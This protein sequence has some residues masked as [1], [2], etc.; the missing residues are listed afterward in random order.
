MIDWILKPA[1][2]FALAAL[3]HFW[4]NRAAVRHFA[5]SLGFVAIL[6]MPLLP[7][8]GLSWKTKTAVRVPEVLAAID[9]GIEFEGAAAVAAAPAGSDAAPYPA[10]KIAVVAAWLAGVLACLMRL[11]PA[12]WK[13][14][15]LTRRARPV[16][17]YQGVQV[18]EHDAV[19][20]P[21]TWGSL[22]PVI[23]LPASQSRDWTSDRKQHVLAHEF[24]H[25]RR[26][27]WAMQSMSQLA[28]AF[29]WF[30]PL[31]WM[32]AN[33]MRRASEQACD[34]EVVQ[35]GHNPEGYAE[36]LLE[37][38]APSSSASTNSVL[39]VPM[40]DR[41]QLEDRIMKILE[42][43]D[44]RSLGRA[45]A[46][47][48]TFA[49]LL[50]LTPLALVR[51]QAQPAGSSDKLLLRGV[52]N[53]PSGARVPGA[54]VTGRR[55]LRPG[56][57]APQGE[58]PAVSVTAAD[59]SYQLEVP[60]GPVVVTIELPGFAR[61]E[62]TLTLNSSGGDAA[63]IRD[64]TLALGQ[65]SETVGVAGTRP[66]GAAQRQAGAPTRIRVGGNVQAANLIRKTNPEYP[67]DLQAQGIE[68]TVELEAIISK[69]GNII[70]VHP[71]SK[72]VH[73]GLI[74]AAMAAVNTWQYKPTLLNG[75]P[76]EVVTTV[77]VRFY[78]Q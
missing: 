51:I 47:L 1:I 30:H 58:T 7:S 10:W 26:Q 28:C 77:T 61:T 49:A 57:M 6:A 65:I 22:R 45:A 18:L 33:A 56:E 5:W 44:R 27:D 66:P 24:A 4:A 11:I 34:D 35:N 15:R 3:V 71:K 12:W 67:Q 70:N 78:L 53:D 43:H 54:K 2:V 21:F 48:M 52:V 74:Q 19:E 59:G 69:E 31:V 41:S 32:A 73:E 40:W 72:L 46:T 9:P 39:V 68:G 75:N 63:F 8:S 60:R 55:A 62:R 17:T 42:Q 29:Y 37:L 38:A 13:V 36:H 16:G 20:T 76:V 25:V 50:T 64:F 23:V 14:R